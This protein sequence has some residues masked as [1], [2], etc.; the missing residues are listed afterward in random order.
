MATYYIPVSGYYSADKVFLIGPFLNKKKVGAWVEQISEDL[1]FDRYGHPKDFGNLVVFPLISKTF[2]ERRF[3]VALREGRVISA[4][5][6]TFDSL[7]RAIEL[8]TEY[9]DATR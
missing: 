6:P 5:A 4:T 7:Q 9:L 8:Q 1:R 2:A 3:A